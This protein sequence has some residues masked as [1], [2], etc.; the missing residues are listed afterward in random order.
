MYLCSHS[1]RAYFSVPKPFTTRASSNSRSCTITVVTNWDR[2]SRRFDWASRNHRKP[3][4]T[5]SEVCECLLNFTIYKEYYMS[6]W[7]KAHK[8]VNEILSLVTALMFE[9]RVAI[10]LSYIVNALIVI[11]RICIRIFF[12]QLEYKLSF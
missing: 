1:H 12:V 8:I 9:L 10:I 6:F 4:T 7:I 5:A 2:K 11:K 3:L